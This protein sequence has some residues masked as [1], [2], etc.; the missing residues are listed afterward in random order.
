MKRSASR[1]LPV[2]LALGCV[3]GIASAQT[4]TRESVSTA[5]VQGNDDSVTPSISFDGRY[6]AFASIATNLTSGDSNGRQDIF[7]R[8]RQGST[9]LMS[10]GTL[11]ETANLPCTNPVISGD[12]R[13]VA[14]LS[15]SNSLVPTDANNAPDIFLADSQSPGVVLVTVDSFGVQANG[16]SRYPAIS[17][18]GRYVA[19]SSDST[20]LVPADTNNYSDIFVRDTIAGTTIRISF[21]S[22]GSQSDSSSGQYGIAISGN[23]NIVAFSSEAH[24]GQP[25]ATDTWTDIFVRDVQAGQTTFVSASSEGVPGNAYSRFPSISEDGRYVAFQSAA[26]NLVSDDTNGVDDVFVH[27]MQT[28][29]TFRVSLDSNGVEGNGASGHPAISP[30]GRIVTFDSVASNLVSDDT[31]GVSDAFLRDIGAQMTRRV[32]VST[33]G[34]QSDGPSFNPSVARFGR[35]VAFE[36]S[37]T[38]IVTPDGNLSPDIFVHEPRLVIMSS[39][40]PNAGSLSGGDVVHLRGVDFTSSADTVV[41]FGGVA[42][43]IT[44]VTPSQ[45]DVLTP[46]GAATGPVEVRM[47][48]TNGVGSL[49]NAYRYAE[50]R[51]AARYG[52]VNV[53]VGDRADVLLV[54]VSPGDLVTRE[55]IVPRRQQI[56]LLVTSPPSRPTARFAVYAWLLAADDTTLTPLPRG[57]GAMAC[58]PPFAHR[59]PAPSLIFNNIGHVAVLGRSSRPSNP[60]LAPTVLANAPHGSRRT[61][62]ATLQGIIQDDGSELTEGFSVTNAVVVLVP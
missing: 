60:P 25:G 47:Q 48:N 45:V 55:L 58:P 2:I 50:P 14:F 17:G 49:P 35:Q 51:Y 44:S 37:G 3:C 54:N 4:T 26:S 39:I 10:V 28:S 5:G 20:N 61:A 57:L 27:D 41:T 19:F 40:S 46:P 15:S 7:W 56:S 23:G 32:S 24:F 52:R 29:Q 42:A 18:D 34:L 13:W 59:A 36:S 62:V 16:Y 38:N 8:D 1:T 53:G 11:G 22:V 43:T 30:D 31:N 21:D 12:G 9:L 6:L 33:S